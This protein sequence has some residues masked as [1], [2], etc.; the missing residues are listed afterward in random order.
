MNSC[1]GIAIPTTERNTTATMRSPPR[2][3]LRTDEAK[4]ML[5]V[6]PKHSRVAL[7]NRNQNHVV[8]PLVALLVIRTL[9]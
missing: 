3:D 9:E 7:V 4:K 5:E 1:E 6:N 2:F 8:T